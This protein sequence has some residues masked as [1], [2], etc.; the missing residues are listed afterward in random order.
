M[1]HNRFPQCVIATIALVALV[2]CGVLLPACTGSQASTVSSESQA[3]PVRIGTYESRAVAVAYGRSS[4][5][6]QRMKQL[7][8]E[9]EA[10]QQAGNAKLAEQLEAQGRQMQLRMHLQAF[11]NAPVDDVL[12]AVREELPKVAQATNVVAIASTPDYHD[13]S[14]V[15]VDVTDELV[16][17]FNPDK[18]TLK[19]VKELRK[20]TPLAIEEVA[21]M[22][23]VK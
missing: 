13:S 15:L 10:A 19:V 9:H 22:P 4:Q 12:N 1:N 17:L 3:S 2:L 21:K 16:Q 20:S 6:A 7:H 5:L 14:V 8:Q 11:S 18:Q 23:V